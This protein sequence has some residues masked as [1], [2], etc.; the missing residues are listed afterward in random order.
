MPGSSVS[1]YLDATALLYFIG[2]SNQNSEVQF[3]DLE[4]SEWC[5]SALSLSE[6]LVMVGQ[7]SDWE[8]GPSEAN[9]RLRKLWDHLFVIPVDQLCLE[10]AAIIAIDFQVKVSVAIHIAAAERL[11]TPTFFITADPTQLVVAEAVG[12]TSIAV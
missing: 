1:T 6:A 8:Q 5:T 12:M 7:L 4:E 2:L 3:S 9:R 10:R 11:P